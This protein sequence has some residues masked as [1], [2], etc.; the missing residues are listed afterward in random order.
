MSNTTSTLVTHITRL[1]VHSYFFPDLVPEPLHVVH[2]N[3]LDRDSFLQMQMNRMSGYAA[4]AN[5]LLSGCVG[6]WV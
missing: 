3:F 6:V 2:G 1:T 4:N 5:D